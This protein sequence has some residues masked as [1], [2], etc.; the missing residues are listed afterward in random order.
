[1]REKQGEPWP[2]KLGGAREIAA[3][4]YIE[5]M[6]ALSI[7]SLVATSAF[8]SLGHANKRAVDN[9]VHTCA[10]ALVQNQIDAF[11]TAGPFY[12]QLDPPIVPPELV[13]AKS[14]PTMPVYTDPANNHVTVKGSMTR[15]V[16]DLE[17]AQ[18][19]NGTTDN[20]HTRRLRVRLDYTLHGKKYSVVMTTLRAADL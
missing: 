20:L 1:M 3:F 16:A 8:T 11:L 10:Q 19:T 17:L 15:M 14:T 9:R 12:P 6:V 4:T 7:L 18:A 13:V 5:V 2:G